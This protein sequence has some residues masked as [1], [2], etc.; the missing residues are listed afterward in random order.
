MSTSAA[1][2]AV[3]AADFIRQTLVV[4]A[5]EQKRASEGQTSIE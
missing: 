1:I 5:D 4:E 3:S 2:G